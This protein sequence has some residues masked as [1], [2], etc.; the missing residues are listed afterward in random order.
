[1]FLSAA[2]IASSFL[3]DL[4]NIK[5]EGFSVGKNDKH[6]AVTDHKI[7]FPTA[8]MQL[9][10]LAGGFVLLY[11]FSSESAVQEMLTTLLSCILEEYFFCP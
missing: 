6:T 2:Y 10:Y 11:D 9:N 1:M 4:T 7:Y 8:S 3:K 5:V